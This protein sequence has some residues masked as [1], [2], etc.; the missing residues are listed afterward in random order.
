LRD[1]GDIVRRELYEKRFEWL[2]SEVLGLGSFQGLGM[3][4]NEE[5]IEKGGWVER[6]L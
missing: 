2:C 5:E 1:R 4:S 3:K 6:V